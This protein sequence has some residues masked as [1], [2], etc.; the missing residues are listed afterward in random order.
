[1][2]LLFKFILNLF[3]VNLKTCLCNI[4]PR[5]YFIS[6]FCF[7]VDFYSTLKNYTLALSVII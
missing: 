2:L 7:T 4:L 3:D 5:N 6:L 1:M